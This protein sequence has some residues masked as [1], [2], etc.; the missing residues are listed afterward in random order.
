MTFTLKFQGHI[1]S[2]TAAGT[3]KLQGDTILLKYDY[4]NYETIFATYREQNKQVPI[5]IQLSASRVVLRPTT[6]VKKH[7][8]FYVV[9]ET[10]GL[11]KTYVKNGKTRSVYLQ[12]AK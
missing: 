12:R 5:D 8:K 2:D 10:T 9:D 1:S 4:N 6:L 7:S 3:Y 11:T